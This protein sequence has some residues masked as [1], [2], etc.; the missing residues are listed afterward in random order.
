[1]A[2]EYTLVTP[3]LH[4]ISDRHSAWPCIPQEN[5][6]EETMAYF[7]EPEE[8]HNPRVCEGELASP[9]PPKGGMPAIHE[10][11]IKPKTQTDKDSKT[12]TPEGDTST[13]TGFTNSQSALHMMKVSI[14]N[15]SPVEG[16]DT[17][18][19]EPGKDCHGVSRFGTWIGHSIP[20]AHWNTL[21][22]ALALVFAL[23]HLSYSQDHGNDHT[24]CP[25]LKMIRKNDLFLKSFDVFLQGLLRSEVK[26]GRLRTRFELGMAQSK[27][28][29]APSEAIYEFPGN[30][31]HFCTT[32]PWIIS[33]T[34]AVFW[35]VCWRFY[36]PSD[37]TPA[38]QVGGAA[39]NDRIR[40]SSTDS[41]LHWNGMD[42]DKTPGSYPR[43][44][45]GSEQSATTGVRSEETSPVKQFTSLS[46]T[47]P[48]GNSGAANPMRLVTS[49]NNSPQ[50]VNTDNQLAG[51][52]GNRVRL[53]LRGRSSVAAR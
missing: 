14:S 34:L 33:P 11:R 19:P 53:P 27:R 29:N 12:Q 41:G 18:E 26:S 16:F 45:S 49:Q 40:P 15:L 38:I 47:P 52:Q 37:L 20:E 35:G 31:R 5:D 25:S 8:H 43:T 44:I 28:R 30:M 23:L 24:M 22:E 32:M 2:L 1:M 39:E 51:G 46:N 21:P 3:P 9:V 4:C 17:S 48:A 42:L 7:Q 6:I 50:G 10:R 13:S 36:P